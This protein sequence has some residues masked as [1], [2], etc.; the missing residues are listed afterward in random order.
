MKKLTSLAI[1]GSASLALAAC[2]GTEDASTEAT[3]DTVEM[4]ADEALE[5]VTDE[6][7]EDTAATEEPEE[8]GDAT[9]A[10]PQE[11]AEAAGDAAADV[12]AEAAAAA[13]AA[14]AAAG[15][16]LPVEE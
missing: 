4:P 7:V 2:G 15:I 8:T 1:L 9:A 13:E 5:A 14:E 12:A 6:P 11:T 10:V 16:E 3:A